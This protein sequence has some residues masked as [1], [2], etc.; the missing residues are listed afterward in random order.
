MTRKHF[1]AIAAI[2][3]ADYVSST[4]AAQVKVKVL[5]YSLADYFQSINANFN[6]EQFYKAVGIV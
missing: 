1:E 6:R 5:T 4:G 2:L 3:N